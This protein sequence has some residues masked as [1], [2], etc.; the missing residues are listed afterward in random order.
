MVFSS[1]SSPALTKDHKKL[2]KKFEKTCLLVTQEL[3]VKSRCVFSWA[4]DYRSF[5]L[6]ASLSLTLSPAPTYPPF[7]RPDPKYS[8]L[9]PLPD[10]ATMDMEAVLDSRV[11]FFTEA[12]TVGNRLMEAYLCSLRLRYDEKQEFWETVRNGI[13]FFFGTFVLDVVIGIV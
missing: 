12:T 3:N 11:R 2:Y 6:R 7:F 8:G 4:G 1:L 5:V 9:Q 10:E 13:L